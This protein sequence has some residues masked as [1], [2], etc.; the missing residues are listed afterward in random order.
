MV[1]R[2][3]RPP[4]WRAR[5]FSRR[6]WSCSTVPWISL[7]P[8][9]RVVR[10]TSG[11]RKQVRY[12]TVS[13]ATRQQN[14]PPGSTASAVR[15]VVRAAF[16]GLP[17]FREGALEGRAWDILVAPRAPPQRAQDMSPKNLR[18]ADGPRRH[19]PRPPHWQRSRCAGSSRTTTSDGAPAILKVDRLHGDVVRTFGNHGSSSRVPKVFR[20]PAH[21]NDIFE[22]VDVTCSVGATDVTLGTLCAVEQQNASLATLAIG[23]GHPIGLACSNYVK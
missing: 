6:R 18:N 12:P 7:L 1:A 23:K 5:A 19:T 9:R 11:S 22:A 15:R 16:T 2:P 14:A 21:R 13:P 10:E 20:E 17:P 8:R 4:A 3:F